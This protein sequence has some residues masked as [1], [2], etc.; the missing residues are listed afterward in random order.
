MKKIANQIPLIMVS[1]LFFTACK[2]SEILQSPTE[3]IATASNSKK[4][5]TA[6]SKIKT[7]TH[8]NGTSTLT[9]IYDG[10]GRV[11]QFSGPESTTF[12]FQN[13]MDTVF[14][15]MFLET[16]PQVGD[17]LYP[18]NSKGL[19]TKMDLGVTENIYTYNA[20]KNL[21][22]DKTMVGNDVHL[23]TH[24]YAGGNLAETK[25]TVNGILKWTKT[26]TYYTDKLN[27]IGNEAF[28]QSYLGVDSK[29][30]VKS[31][32]FNSVANGI[33]TTNYSY[34][35]DPQGRVSKQMSFYNGLS[36]PIYT[37]TYY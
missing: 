15:T 23:M 17:F 5:Q 25:Y 7:R 16:G 37:Y 29:N 19:A 34:E 18:I 11:M 32:T 24:D 31:L 13:E 26:Y 10:N 36:L 4:P 30:L 35:F 14:V 1:I 8:G 22:E 3:E 2:K 6:V 12:L 33:T 21:I 28:G 27:S 9:Y 20:K